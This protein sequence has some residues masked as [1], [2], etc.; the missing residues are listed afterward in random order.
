MKIWK[1]RGKVHHSSKIPF[2]PWYVS[3]V[4]LLLFWILQVQQNCLLWVIR[5]INQRSWFSSSW[6]S[7]KIQSSKK[8]KGIPLEIA[9][10]SKCSNQVLGLYRKVRDIIEAVDQLLHKVLHKWWQRTR[11]LVGQHIA[12]GTLSYIAKHQTQAASIWQEPLLSTQW[13]AA[14]RSLVSANQAL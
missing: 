3:F 6:I 12:K 9:I 13:E 14:T 8:K 10:L 4:I 11:T 2:R 5:R 1:L 7:V